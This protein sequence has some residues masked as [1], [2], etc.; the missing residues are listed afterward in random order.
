MIEALAAA[1]A[2]LRGSPRT[3]AAGHADAEDADTLHRLLARHGLALI[4]AELDAEMRAA[5]WRAHAERLIHT[6]DSRA[7]FVAARLASDHQAEADRASYASIIAEAR[8]RFDVPEAP[9]A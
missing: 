6:P 3:D 4:P 7:T 8:R 1:L 5:I 9:A 2:E